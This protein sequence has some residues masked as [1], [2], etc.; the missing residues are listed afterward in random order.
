MNGMA[1]VSICSGNVAIP[2]ERSLV[3]RK[4][5]SCGWDLARVFRAASRTGNG[6]PSCF[7]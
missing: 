1:S 3:P 6:H 2:D 5:Q 4:I 7:F